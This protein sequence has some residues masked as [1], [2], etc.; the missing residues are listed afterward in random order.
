MKNEEKFLERRF[1]KLLEVKNLNVTFSN[2]I[3]VENVSFDI[4]QGEYVCIVGENGSGKSTLLRTIIGLKKQ[5]SGTIKIN[6][7][8]GE[9]SYL[10]QTNLKDLKFPATSKEIIL[11]GTQKHGKL[12]FYS[13]KDKEIY[14]KVIKELKIEDI[15]NKRIGDLSGGQKQRVL[16]ARAL[17]REPKLLI[18]DEPMTGLDYNIT[19]EL[20]NLLNDLNKKE[21]I[22]IIMATHDLDEIKH[23]NPRIIH[24]AKSVKYD[25]NLSDWKGY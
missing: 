5:D 1:M 13:K 7:S 4:N 3:A 12:P 6:I 10:A 2:H 16:I 14:D 24:I 11:S 20:Y 9:I 17:V 15:Q 25:G 18:L 22:T 8:L 21:N 23:D 19:N